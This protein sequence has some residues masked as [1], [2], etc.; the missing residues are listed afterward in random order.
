MFAKPMLRER[1]PLAAAQHINEQQT[2]MEREKERV[3]Q[4]LVTNQAKLAKKEN[5]RNEQIYATFL[6]VV[7]DGKELPYVQCVNCKMILS[8]EAKNGTS[9]L[10][11]HATTACQLRKD[12]NFTP[13]QSMTSYV[14]KDRKS[15][16]SSSEKSELCKALARW[17]AINTRP[18]E[19]VK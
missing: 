15:Q 10:N 8:H 19:I 12:K 13:Q 1:A 5:V 17:C 2:V 7:M 4:L 16:A 3:R 6:C 18:F 9:T 11:H 14:K